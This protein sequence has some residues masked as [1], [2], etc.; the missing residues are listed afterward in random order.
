MPVA[1][2][3]PVLV[4]VGAVQQRLEDPVAAREPVELMIA[5]LEQA[6][7]DA[8]CRQLLAQASSIRVPR[9]FWDYA[10]PGRLIAQRIG[11][12]GARTQLAEIGIL[13]TS[14]FG[15]AARAIASGDDEVVLIA[16]GEAKYRTLRAQI[17]GVPA[18]LTVQRGIEPDSVLSPDREIISPLEVDMGLMMPVTQYSFMENALRYAEGVGIDAHRREVAELWAD[19][20]RVATAN[21]NAVNRT[22]VSAAAIGSVTN[23][24]RMLA[25]PYTKLHNSQWNVDQAAGLILCSVAAARAAGVPEERWVF[26]LA[27]AESNHMVPLS[28]RRALHR[29][30]GF[31]LAGGQALEWSGLDIHAVRHLELY[32]C[33]PIAVRIQTRELGIP[34]DRCL[35]VT[36]GMAFAGGPLN[37]FVLQALARMAAILRADRTHAGMVTAVSG[38]LTKQGVSLWAAHP[39]QRPFRFI[40]VTADVAQAQETVPLVGDYHGPATVASYTVIYEGDVPARA[41]M[42]CD[43]PDGRRTLAASTDAALASRATRQELCGGRVQ[44]GSGRVVDAW[45]G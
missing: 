8:G 36:G 39:P 21:P 9:G 30:P 31:R 1:P 5:A 15:H 23:G 33:F 22:A 10:D 11:A 16:G 29:S 41:V 17:A 38:M 35:T 32:S 24:N 40:D 3:T 44:I 2:R 25:F 19:F 13:Q 27:V 4:G 18:P 6:A 43:L 28:A 45:I 42:I 14:L 7:D 12:V 20:S 37:N 34:P 26:P